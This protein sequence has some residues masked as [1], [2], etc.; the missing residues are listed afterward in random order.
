MTMIPLPNHEAFESMLRPRSSK[1]EQNNITYPPWTC[2]SFSA[3]WCGPCKRLNKDLIVKLSPNVTWYSCDVDENTY[4]LGF[5][6]LHSIPGFC[7]IKDGVFKNR[8]TGA[9]SEQEVIDWLKSNGV[10]I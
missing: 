3:K 4:T 5:C 7:L 6:G 9:Q 10:P 8:K 2:I 1:E